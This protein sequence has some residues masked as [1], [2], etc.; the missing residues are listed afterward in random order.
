MS[1]SRLGP[2]LLC[3]QLR[4]GCLFSWKT[5]HALEVAFESIDV[6]GPEPAELSEP[7]VHLFQWFGFQTI[8][9]ALCVY[10]GLY[11]AC[12]AQHS[13]MLGN[14]RLRH[15]KLTLDLSN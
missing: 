13:Q 10:R 1:G 4:F 8:K 2:H 6:R 12:I 9:T 14:R 15:T 5:I 3:L 7:V 11:E